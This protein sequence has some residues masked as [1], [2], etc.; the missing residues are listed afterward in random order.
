MTTKAE[1][2]ERI[3]QLEAELVQEQR[4]AEHFLD[5]RDQLTQV[6]ISLVPQKSTEGA[7]SNG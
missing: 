1:L 4:R 2:A 6:L 5:Q 7:S 3:D